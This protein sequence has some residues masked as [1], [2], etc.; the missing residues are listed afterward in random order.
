MSIGSGSVSKT[1]LV[2]QWQWHSDSYEKTKTKRQRHN[3]SKVKKR[4]RQKRTTVAVAVAQWQSGSVTYAQ[5]QQQT[6]P[7]P[8]YCHP[9]HPKTN[10]SPIKMI[11]TP[12]PSHSTATQPLPH[13]PT[14]AGSGYSGSVALTKLNRERPHALFKL[15]DKAADPLKLA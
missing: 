7:L 5:W 8:H 15:R 2:K 3:G 11:P 12:F 10:L 9:S 14:V 4:N 13:P 6:T 1:V